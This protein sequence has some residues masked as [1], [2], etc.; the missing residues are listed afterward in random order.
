MR[1]H[2]QGYIREPIDG[3]RGGDMMIGCLDTLPKSREEG[4][5][6]AGDSSR[7]IASRSRQKN[8]FRKTYNDR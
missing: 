5:M 6:Y 1:G 4:Q 3:E 2:L 7:S 8:S